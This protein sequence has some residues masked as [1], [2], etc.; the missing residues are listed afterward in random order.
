MFTAQWVQDKLHLSVKM[1]EPTIGFFLLN[2]T[3]VM[4]EH[5]NFIKVLNFIATSIQ[6]EAGDG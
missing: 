3:V 4:P 2:K 6:K 5:E 1:M